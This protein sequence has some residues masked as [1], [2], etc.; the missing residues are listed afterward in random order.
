IASETGRTAVSVLGTIGALLS[1]LYIGRLVSLTFLGDPRSEEAEHAHES[2]LVMLAPLVA[3]AVGAIGLGVLMLDPE[4]GVLPGF[5]EPVLG[6]VPQGDA[7]VGAAALVVISQVMALGGLGAAW[8][9][10]ASGRVD[11]LALRL[12]LAPLQR[13]LAHGMYVDDLYARALVAPAT[14]GS[15]ILATVVD[16]RG[17]DGLVNAVGRL[18]RSLAAVGRRVQ[19]GLVRTYALAFLLGALALLAY[20]GVRG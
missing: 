12:R 18:V 1:A 8:F 15:A 3:L 2:P 5:L 7:G 10:Y 9:V 14:A 20:V 13:L 4:T 17:V 6:A 19:T 11:W 16:A